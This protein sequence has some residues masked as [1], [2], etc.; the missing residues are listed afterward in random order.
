MKTSILLLLQ[1]TTTTIIII[2]AEIQAT[3]VKKFWMPKK[4]PEDQLQL[5]GLGN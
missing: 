4:I 5:Q 1:T 2:D 3:D